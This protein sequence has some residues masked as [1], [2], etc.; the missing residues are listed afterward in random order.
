MDQQVRQ[1][2]LQ[3]GNNKTLTV[4]VSYGGV[5]QTFSGS[6]EAVWIG[7][8]KFF[9]RF[10]PAF[11]TAKML[12]LSV[13]L[14][15]LAGECENLIGLEKEG[16]Y[17]L[18]P[19]TMLT[20]NELLSMHL[21][22]GYLANQLGRAESS[23]VS[24]EKLQARLGKDAKILSTRLGELVKNQLAAKTADEKYCI[25]SYGLG[26]LRLCLHDDTLHT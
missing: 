12:S 25:T 14:K 24:K 10:L 23:E 17:V 5:E 2:F 13:D 8:G 3:T 20:D 22:A 16:P 18:V 19:R 21:L 11:E 26:Q 15:K 1:P 6:V 4:H 7:L 9:S